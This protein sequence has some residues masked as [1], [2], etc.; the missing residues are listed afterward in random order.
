M[1]ET[2][3]LLSATGI[4]KSFFGVEVLKGIDYAVN[5]GS[6]LGLVGENGAGKSTLMNILGGG[7]QS[8]QGTML[9]NGE[10]FCP[11]GPLEAEQ[12][13]IGFIHQE[14]NLFPNLTIAENLF[15]NDFPRLNRFIPL[16]N[17]RRIVLETQKALAEVG[18]DRDPTTLVERLSPGERQ[19]VEIA[20]ALRQKARILIFD[21]PTT[22]LAEREIQRLFEIIH[23]LKQQGI[24][25]IYISHNLAHI[26]ELCE[27][28]LVLRDGERVAGGPMKQFD[29]DRLVTLMVGRSIENL[30]PQPTRTPTQT[31]AFVVKNLSEPNIVKGISF[32]VR[33]GEVVGISGLMGS[34]RSEL[35]RILFGLDP[36]SEGEIWLHGHLLS[37]RT[38]RERVH[39]GMAFLTEDRRIEGL[40]LE[41]SIGDNIALVSLS[42]FT[43]KPLGLID[44]KRLNTAVK[45]IR[46]RTQLSAQASDQQAVKT[47]SGGNQQKVVLAKWL[48][49]EP[50]LLILDEP[51]RGIDVG[52]KYEIYTLI[53]QLAARGKSVLVVS[54]EMEELIGICDRILVMSRGEITDTIETHEFDRERILKA[55]L[56][57]ESLS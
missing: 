47:L 2:L 53:D 15:I 49:N 33:R 38:P 36:C 11:Q 37:G 5:A 9:L 1:G 42:K 28:V 30:F 13:G 8:N 7:L 51:T 41:G 26:Q 57:G 25:L 40:T 22:S 23:R 50:E 55:A 34:G 29:I 10:P 32:E 44:R 35:M 14:L 24:A 3:P 54:S 12:A 16:I 45:D 19:L 31:A 43:R 52:A 4:R 39:A 46:Q 18:L 48:L 20:K 6:A 17:K 27:D 56:Q 21:E